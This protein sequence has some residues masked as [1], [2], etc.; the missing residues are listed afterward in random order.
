MSVKLG[1]LS[2]DTLFHILS[3]FSLMEL[4]PNSGVYHLNPYWK[5]QLNVY[6]SK[7]LLSTSGDLYDLNS[8][9]KKEWNNL[10]FSA[11][12]ILISK[13]I[14]DFEIFPQAAAIGQLF[15]QSLYGTK[16]QFFVQ[17]RAR[18]LFFDQLASTTL[19]KKIQADPIWNA[20]DFEI[21]LEI[22]AKKEIESSN[23]STLFIDWIEKLPQGYNVTWERKE[24][25]FN[26]AFADWLVKNKQTEEIL[27][28]T[29]KRS[30]KFREYLAI[31]FAR[32]NNTELIETLAE[33]CPKQTRIRL[34]NVCAKGLVENRQYEKAK[35]Y[36]QKIESDDS[37]GL[38]DY[39]EFAYAS[40]KNGDYEEA[41]NFASQDFTHIAHEF[42]AQAC[43]ELGR[44]ELVEA[45]VEKAEFKASEVKRRSALGCIKR[46]D[47]IQADQFAKDSWD[48]KNEA[49]MD[50]AQECAR[51]G[52]SIQANA[53][54]EK[55]GNKTDE[56]YAACAAAFAE[57]NNEKIAE[58]FARMAGKEEGHAYMKCAL[59]F[60]ERG[61]LD[62]MSYF[63]Q[64]AVAFMQSENE[65]DQ[66][67]YSCALIL[68][69]SGQHEI[70]EEFI[71]KAGNHKNAAYAACS[72]AFTKRGKWSDAVSFAQKAEDQ[73]RLAYF[74]SAYY[75]AD[76]H[77]SEDA[78]AF[79]N[80]IQNQD[81]KD[82]FYEHCI[83]CF[84]GHGEHE[85][86]KE[87]VQLASQNLSP[88]LNNPS[89]DEVNILMIF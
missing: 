54:I 51:Q 16:H 80:L 59:T 55:A 41:E 25:I 10:K 50:C 60:A 27:L 38:V 56:A 46:G 28:M 37:N 88:L 7:Y 3:Y 33:S 19:I 14:A 65:T 68:A 47:S 31:A 49:Y 82:I 74:H 84:A 30:L 23:G 21:Y 34:Y 70:A 73:A 42:Y 8:A 75:F 69:V 5:T 44:Y 78:K 67:Y 89:D 35:E 22:L 48:K 52:N 53:F 76:Q 57:R 61:R 39:F 32:I 11:K 64:K 71:K 87:F 81:H 83:R 63:I 1:S 58:E 26:Q 36:V 45:I 13:F 66:L 2:S 43:S 40:A 4:T 86:A 17:L 18:Q 15:C 62:Q 24:E 29:S 12:K 85:L 77:H 79:A 72:H 20:Q 6:L 9:R